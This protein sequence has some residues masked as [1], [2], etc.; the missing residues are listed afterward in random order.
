M[1]VC[2]D[3]LETGKGTYHTYC[4]YSHHTWQAGWRV[5]VRYIFSK[6]RIAN[7]SGSGRGPSLAEVIAD[8][9]KNKPKDAVSVALQQ[10]RASTLLGSREQ[11]FIQT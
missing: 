11:P 3:S 5:F 1:Q 6:R 10:D 4:S 8:G 9:A 2:L 7:S